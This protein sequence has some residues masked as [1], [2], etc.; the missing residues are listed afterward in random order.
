MSQ[1][2]QTDN[3]QEAALRA[4][5]NRLVEI[6]ADAASRGS[7]AS[8][9]F[10]NQMYGSPGAPVF[11]K[12]IEMCSL[13]LGMEVPKKADAPVEVEQISGRKAKDLVLDDL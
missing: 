10:M 13:A 8:M 6:D 7:F 2:V 9:I 11:S 1:T 4:V 3:P 12:E 5:L